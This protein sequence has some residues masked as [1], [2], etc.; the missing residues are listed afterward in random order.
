MKTYAIINQ[1]VNMAYLTNITKARKD[2]YKLAEM[3]IEQNMEVNINTKKGNV[4]LI[5]EDEY[6]SLLETIYLSSNPKY[7]K[8]LVDGLN[9]KYEDTLGEDDI[10]W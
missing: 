4:V 8:T 3:A 9:L 6:R 2:I 10:K 5:S 1:E 7:K